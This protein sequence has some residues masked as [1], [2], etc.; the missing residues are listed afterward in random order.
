MA[1]THPTLF[2]TVDGTGQFDLWN[3]NVDTKEPTVSTQT[4][5]GKALNN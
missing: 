4:G 5:S 3:L 2:G 1:P